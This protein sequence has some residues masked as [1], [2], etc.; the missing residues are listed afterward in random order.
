MDR[1]LL[2][3]RLAFRRL[4]QNPGFSIVAILTLALGIGAN[5]AIFSVI[6]TV[7]I[8]PLP[9]ERSTELVS[10]NETLNGDSYPTLSF[11]NYRDLRDRNTV[12]SGLIA[13]RF[14]PASLGL[15]GS[16]QRLWGY[17]VSG[18][19]FQVLG[20]NAIRGRVILPEDDAKRGAHPVAVL[21][22]PCWQKQ[23]GADP[24]AVGRTVKFNG[25]D[26]TILG[27]APRGFFGTELY[28]AP[29][30]FFP[31]AM[32]KELEGGNGFLEERGDSNTF[33]VGRRKPGVTLAQAESALN[34]IAR[35]LAQEYPK[36]DA[37]MKIMLT[38][39]GLAGNYIRGAVIGFAAV[40]FGVSSLVLLVACTNLA[41]MLLARAA[42]RRKETAIRLALGAE[43]GR[44]VRQLLTESLVIALAGGAGGALVGYWIT[45]ALAAWRLP[46]DIPIFL[47]VGADARVF[48][49]AFL[50]SAATTLLFGLLPALQA[51]KAD[52]VP[53]LKNEAGSE[54]FRHWHLRDYTVAAQVALST[55]LLVCSVLVI[56]SFQRAL[57]APIGYN[58]KGA[59][60]VA[61]DL[62]IQGYDE[63]R[64]RQFQRR[65]LEKVRA[66][67]GIDS[68]ALID[69][70]PLSLNTSSSSIYIEG[71]PK[72]KAAEAPIA[73]S[74]DASP[75][76]FRTMQTSLLS[77]RDFDQR[78]KQDGKRVAIVNQ[79]FAQQMLRGE[80]PIGRRFGTGPDGKPIE[81]IGVAE[82]GKYF[83]LAEAQ[84]P[85]FWRPM[86][87]W[88]SSNSALVARTKLNGPEAL[89]E[90]RAAV[91]DLDPTIALYSTGTLLDQLD[92]PLFPARIAASA[93]G[94][95]GL[96][97][98]IL[99]ATGIYG[100]M[101]YAI[102]R[103]TREI[104]IRMAIG[105]GQSQVLGMVGK[106]ALLLIGSGTVIGLAAALVVGRLLAQILYGIQPTDPTTFAIVFMM[107]LGVAGVACWIPAR[108]AIRIDPIRA[109]RQ[110]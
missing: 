43:R 29:D 40:L 62:N 9:V 74:Y 105:A 60:T 26:F 65:L 75:G 49:F 89:G 35:Q 10:L 102:S 85:A 101:A 6:N 13:Y 98:L 48:L 12:L 53:A 106:H 55:L 92:F 23:F 50:A 31:M 52:L 110:E 64:G 16:S 51:T 4:I 76:Y 56:R 71:K 36:E 73:Y 78:D 39:P 2:D 7:L 3:L 70:L 107:M 108:R 38:P 15:P 1:L 93:L 83:S 5:T 22:Y 18:N 54:R 46:I 99:A 58:P 14:L 57:D 80:D 44:L 67:P 42:D 96:L 66:L 47:N 24:G 37:G 68:A 82:T 69:T 104:G 25:M 95:F 72:P 61:F 19:Y 81:I 77:G 86:E 11:P 21:S 91:R 94:A 32:Q 88:Y 97:A 63:P 59:V 100:V 109:L 103:R 79:A 45:S 27:V 20:V 8:R 87:I 17:L 28:Y 33:I 34:S 84:K 30:V 90:I 41:S